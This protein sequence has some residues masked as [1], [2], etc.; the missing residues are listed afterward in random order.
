MIC[1]LLGGRNGLEH[2]FYVPSSG[3][4]VSPGMLNWWID[5]DS[6]QRGTL[7]G[8]VKAIYQL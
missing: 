8:T 7:T 1:D 3:G 6:N 4:Q 5:G 2:L